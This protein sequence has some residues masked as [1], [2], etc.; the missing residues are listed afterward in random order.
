MSAQD[1]YPDPLLSDNK[2]TVA[3]LKEMAGDD[4]DA[5]AEIE[6]WGATRQKRIAILRKFIAFLEKNGILEENGQRMEEIIA[7]FTIEQCFAIATKYGLDDMGYEF[8]DSLSG[9]LTGNMHIDFQAVMSVPVEPPTDIFESPEQAARFL[10]AIRGKD[11]FELGKMAK[12]IV[13]TDDQRVFP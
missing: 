10:D 11:V 5:I 2:V 8:R 3:Y 7:E 13:L 6:E 9:T 1:T 4:R 12:S